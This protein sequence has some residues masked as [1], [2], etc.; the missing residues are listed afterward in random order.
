MSV[1]CPGPSHHVQ[2]QRVQGV[3][4]GEPSLHWRGTGIV[5]SLG[6]GSCECVLS[7]TVQQA[8]DVRGSFCP[9]LLHPKLKN[10][11]G[12]NEGANE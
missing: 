12:M 11:E 8:H 1:H 9:L 6:L 3:R 4:A 10:R 2:T 7:V 5:P